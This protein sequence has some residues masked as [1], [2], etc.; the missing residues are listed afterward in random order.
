VWLLQ[1]SLCKPNLFSVTESMACEQAPCAA[2][3]QLDSDSKVIDNAEQR[4]EEELSEG[5]EPLVKRV[6]TDELVADEVVAQTVPAPMTPQRC[7]KKM[8]AQSPWAKQK[9][10]RPLAGDKNKK[11]TIMPIKGTIMPFPKH[12]ITSA[13][14]GA[15]KECVGVETI[16]NCM[17]TGQ[18]TQ[19]LLLGWQ[20]GVSNC[21]YNGSTSFYSWGL[22]EQNAWVR[23][24][25][26]GS[27]ATNFHQ[28][29]K[30]LSGQ[31]QSSYAYISF[32]SVRHNRDGGKGKVLE[33]CI[34]IKV[35]PECQFKTLTQFVGAE[36]AL[37]MPVL[38]SNLQV[39]CK[40]TDQARYFLKLKIHHVYGIDTYP[41]S[42]E[43][44]S[45]LVID[46]G[47]NALRAAVWPPNTHN[48]LWVEGEHI[49]ILGARINKAYNQVVVNSD[50]VVLEDEVATESDFPQEVTP[51]DLSPPA[52]LQEQLPA[53]E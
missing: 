42:S 23:I 20:D 34:G 33:N 15:W 1:F 6:K 26:W 24:A 2:L 53:A 14:T 12:G 41:N 22:T 31:P 18:T 10:G 47:G 50:A 8:D 43:R 37:P 39:C 46:M 52:T 3:T 36:N 4:D 27:A 5:S 30:T 16:W 51:F 32:S 40:A 35:E 21:G 19:V 44:L 25:S 11:G 17:K 49:I 45:L 38:S 29:L 13:S 48:S 9:V 7:H 28:H